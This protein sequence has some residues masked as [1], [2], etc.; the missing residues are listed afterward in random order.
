MQFWL[1]DFVAG[2][3]WL[4]VALL[5]IA[6][7][8]SLTVLASLVAGVWFAADVL[9]ESV[10]WH[11][12]II[13]HAVLSGQRWWPRSVV[14]RVVTASCYL[15][16]ALVGPWAAAGGAVALGVAVVI[17]FEI[18]RGGTGERF[19]WAACLV[20]VTSFTVP[21][22]VRGFAT[23]E[24]SAAIGSAYA[25]GI[26]VVA[27]LLFAQ[28]R[29][30]TVRSNLDVLVELGVTPIGIGPPGVESAEEVA[31]AL[32][33]RAAHSGLQRELDRVLD[34]LRTSR[35]RLA[36]SSARARAALRAELNER[37]Q[38]PIAAILA[39]QAPLSG[40]AAAHFA[41][42]HS[43]LEAARDDIDRL[44][45]GLAPN[46]LSAG[47]SASLREL[48]R[49]APLRVRL[50]VPSGLVAADLEHAAYFVCAEAL[51]NVIKHAGATT[52]T[53]AVTH[54]DAALRVNVDD[55]GQGGADPRKGRGIVGMR[56]RVEALG[57]SLSVESTPEGTRVTA[58]IPF[59]SPYV[60]QAATEVPP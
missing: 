54:D 13:V 56:D 24:W 49:S 1:P 7:R 55:D 38:A 11:R 39:G 8:G 18:E 46:A 47:L 14:A 9:P 19:A 44:S 4:V 43:H 33:L 26:T 45:L 2:V 30:L 16:A 27:L 50:R 20:A 52:V 22:V 6:G 57:G 23:R 28:A 31:A 60:D 35:H 41:A 36:M 37:V 5:A 17:A 29:A 48:V 15:A 3:A 10:F 51:T 25:G 53:L 12:A 40:D 58:V 42:A 59:R 21:A 32:R 34:E